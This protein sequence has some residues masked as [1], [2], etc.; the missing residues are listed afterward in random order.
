M[1][2]LNHRLDIFIVSSFFKKRKKT[3]ISQGKQ[4]VEGKGKENK[5]FLILSF[6]E[7]ASGY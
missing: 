3:S 7:L 5:R 1:L 4:K 2:E 6:K